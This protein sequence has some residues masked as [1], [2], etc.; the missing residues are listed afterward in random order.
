MKKFHL[1]V[2][3]TSETN[4]F[5]QIVSFKYDEESLSDPSAAISAAVD[6]FLQSDE[7]K[8]FLDGSFCWNDA[9][10]C[11]PTALYIKH[12]L[13]PSDFTSTG[14]LVLGSQQ[15]G[16]DSK[17]GNSPIA[18]VVETNTGAR[19][20]L[21][22][23]GACMG[24]PGPGGWGAILCCDGK[25]IELCGSERNT[26]NNRMELSAA[27]GG[28]EALQNPAIV[29]VISD[30]KY[31]V[32]SV[33]KGWLNNWHRNGWVNSSGNDTPNIDLWKRLLVQ[34]SRHKV[35]FKWVKGHNGHPYDERCDR[36]AV[37][38]CKR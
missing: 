33:E 11:I 19:V 6:D 8:E 25:E 36:L 17:K 3:N 37:N 31:L 21:Y 5:P 22:T 38:Q 15:L 10:F 23:D 18:A 14:L 32:D 26:T 1:I 34:L 12:G 28:L 9:V 35:V 2:N 24:N 20:V 4:V 27:L 16:K 13:N 29:T 30:S 7:A